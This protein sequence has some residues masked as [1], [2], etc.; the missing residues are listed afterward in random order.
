[1]NDPAVEERVRRVRDR[2]LGRVRVVFEAVSDSE[3]A[4]VTAISITAVPTKVR[5]V[6]V[7]TASSCALFWKLFERQSVF[8][9]EWTAQGTVYRGTGFVRSLANVALHSFSAESSFSIEI[10]PTTA[11]T[12]TLAPIKK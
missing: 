8:E 12:R 1:M 7:S 3:S 2:L 4:R 10:A 5:V 6:A 11:I 9:F